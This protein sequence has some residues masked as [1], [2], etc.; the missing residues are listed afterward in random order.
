[1]KK[2]ITIIIIASL[3]LCCSSAS[4]YESA[5]TDDEGVWSLETFD[6]GEEY[7]LNS[8]SGEKIAKAFGYNE[9]GELVEIPLDEYLDIKNSIAASALPESGG[10]A[11]YLTMPMSASS[12]YYD[13]RETSSYVGV[14]TPMKLTADI[15][16][17]A[18]ILGWDSVSL[19][20]DF[21]GETWLSAA[22]KE[23]IQR[24]ASFPWN[25]YVDLGTSCDYRFE[26]PAGYI[27]YIRFTPYMNYTVGDLYYVYVASLV[28]DEIHLGEVWGASPKK[29]A[30]GKCDGLFEL[31]YK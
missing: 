26:I 12:W 24:G 13:Y 3:A 6:S 10:S 20:H 22:M 15:K 28:Y 16:G 4:G 1:M 2:F 31:I 27:G 9:A 17:P 25:I 14:G 11:D 8:V 30:N 7:L 18:A 23:R 19:E 5:E 21:G 29:L